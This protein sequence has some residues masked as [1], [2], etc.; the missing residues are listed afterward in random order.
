M[1]G[2][3]QQQAQ[4][5]ARDF[6]AF[7]EW[8][9]E[10]SERRNPP[11]IDQLHEH[12]GGTDHSVISREWS[13]VEHVNL[14]RA[15]DVWRRQDGREVTVVGLS[16]PRH[17]SSFGLG[18]LLSG[19]GLPPLR[20]GSPDVI[21]LASGPGQTLACWKRALLLVR[22]PCGTYALLVNGPQPH[23]EP[24]VR[25]EVAGVDT[26][27]AQ[28][29][30]SDIDRLRSELNVFRGQSIVVESNRMGGLSLS[31]VQLPPVAREDV[32]L[33][34]EVLGR[35]DRHALGITA[36]AQTLRDAGQHLKRGLLLFGP[37]GTGK[38]HTVRY[39]IGRRPDATRL[40]LQGE[41]LHSVSAVAGLARELAPSVVV[42]EDVDLVAEDREYGQHNPVLFALLEAMDGSAAD[43]DLLF[44]LTTNRAEVLERALVQRPGRVDVA[45]EIARPD[46]PARAR[47]LELYGADVLAGLP[48]DDRAR[49]VDRTD[50]VTASFLKE[51]I[52]RAV[53]AAAEEGRADRVSAHDIHTALDD[54][55]D[56][57]QSVTRSLLGLGDHEADDTDDEDGAPV[58]GPTPGVAP[59]ASYGW[60]AYAPHARRRY[61]D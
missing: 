43:S 35:V 13:P 5:F 32:I 4:Q 58:E 54:L 25:I 40:L 11:V 36:H 37:P 46:G 31:F 15:L 51:L 12:L 56:Q 6:Q 42:L 45:V 27:A 53:L 50:G 2:D 30:L 61:R 60:F 10:V 7:M 28:A 16:S 3:Q 17:F 21:D 47:L 57:S 22:D 23:E 18:E 1:T 14:Q 24:D 41:A 26:G 39:L 9:Q 19:D 49:V 8:T 34:E 55:L 33:P 59:G 38:T 20:T 29:L 44:V 48:E 52:R